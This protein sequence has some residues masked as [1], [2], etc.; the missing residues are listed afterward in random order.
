MKN[1]II[2][3]IGIVA[4]V[5]FITACSQENINK[6][7]ADDRQPVTLTVT[8]CGYS[9]IESKDKPSTR[10]M[11]NEFRTIFTAGDACGLYVVDNGEIKYNNV[12]MIAHEIGT[13]DNIV[14][15]P[16]GEYITS[17]TGKENYYLYYPYQE[18]MIGKIVLTDASDDEFFAPLISKWQIK[19]D[20]SD[21]KSGYS[22]SD[23]MTAK[24]NVTTD[25]KAVSISF[26]MR[27]QTL[28]C[29]LEVPKIEY[30]FTNNGLSNYTVSYTLDFLGDAKAC[31]M[32][33]GT[34]RFLINE[35]DITSPDNM[36]IL[37]ISYDNDTK[38]KILGP[39][40]AEGF[41]GMYMNALIDG[42]GTIE[43]SHTL[44]T[45]DYFMKDGALIS[46]DKQLTDTQ[47][48]NCIG[49]VVYVGHNQND[50]SD[51]NLSGIGEEKC[52]G[53]VAAL[54][55]AAEEKCVW[56]PCGVELGLFQSKEINNLENPDTEWNGYAH[57]QAIINAAIDIESLNTIYPATYHAVVAYEKMFPS[58]IKSSG[59]F[60]P[61]IGQML[62]IK[63]QSKYM[64]TAS[65]NDLKADSYWSSTECSDG[66]GN[67]SAISIDSNSKV[68]KTTKNETFCLVR[69]ILTF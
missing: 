65:G 66:T 44:Q 37:Y 53:Y 59:W 33:D 64:Q 63:A 49:I 28:M 36:T 12:K 6:F 25:G 42:A 32:P 4:A 35:Q 24:G 3:N 29:R 58:P 18:D 19:L 69:P 52:H 20:Q 50:G 10:T 11:E 56:G 22:A 60:L 30:Q 40:P 17:Q 67:N 57:T 43:K 21:Y 51:Y 27:H 48:S 1:N 61:S 26:K 54:Q 23:L 39:P 13:S 46:R 38:R 9:N 68:S 62:E 47:K 7:G 15:K 2:N 31:Q 41:R 45:G 8:D 5:L 16:E 34:Y 55:D 14:W